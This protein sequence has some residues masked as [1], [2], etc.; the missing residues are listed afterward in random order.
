MARLLALALGLAGAGNALAASYYFDCASGNMQTASCWS[1]NIKPLATDNAFLGYSSFASNVTATLNSGSFAAT[2]E[3]LGFSGGYIGTVN[4]S[5]GSHSVSNRLY[6]GYQNLGGF[7]NSGIYNLSG[8]G[9]LTANAETL[10]YNGAGT[11]NQS[12]GMHA[13]STNLTMDANAGSRGTYN[14]NGGTLAVN[15]SILG[16]AGLGYIN[17]NAG[18]MNVG[19]SIN[20]ST[21]QLGIWGGS[22][23]VANSINVERID[24]EGGAPGST[25]TFTQS[26]ALTVT[27]GNLLIASNGG[28]GHYIQTGGA[29]AVVG[30][31]AWIG[32]NN[33]T[34]T[35]TLSGG[36]LSVDP[37]AVFGLNVGYGGN[38]SFIQNGGSFSSGELWIGHGVSST[39]SYN[40]S[41]GD[42]TVTTEYIGYGQSGGGAG[43]FTQSGGTH[44]VNG[45]LYVGISGDYALTGNGTYTLS[46]TGALSA[47]TL[48]VGWRGIGTFNQTGGTSTVGTLS[49]GDDYSGGQGTYN[50][51]GGQLNAGQINV[52]N[53]NSGIIP[54]VAVFNFTG[55][56]LAVG[57]FIGNLANNGGTLAPGASPGTTLV[58]G[59]YTQGETGKLSIEL[60]G[61]G[62]GLFDV[63]QVTG[64]ATLAGELDVTFWNGFSA[65]AGDS[66]DIV[67]ATNL[68]GGFNTLNLATLDTG[69]VWNVAY[70]YDQ[71]ASGTDYVRLSVQAVPE[72]KTYAM[73]LAGLGLV[74]WAARRRANSV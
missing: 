57:T 42:M 22:L 26:A 48:G 12:G 64:T 23:Q 6:V 3:Y 66:F 5:A 61:T 14:L 56:T 58:Q 19:D 50:L 40:L 24:L 8:T 69:L 72:A 68:S 55:G 18:T 46:G 36:S 20:A 32:V 13:V 41:A 37:S 7:T 67:S 53:A 4:H 29:H 21:A 74:G 25:A 70:L 73:M 65:A 45:S 30:S 52:I 34:G 49:L 51:Q 44:T 16:G 35:Y 15:G 54:S 39:G 47:N 62:A 28:S 27:T 9:T 10:G 59:D 33:G 17:I 31:A 71:D 2:N 1:T 38:G 11:I 63:L 43:T 60:G